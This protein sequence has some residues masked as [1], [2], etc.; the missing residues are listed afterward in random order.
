MEFRDV[1]F[2]LAKFI[3]LK[4]YEEKKRRINGPN[5]M[6]AYSSISQYYDLHMSSKLI[7]SRIQAVVEVNCEL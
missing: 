1:L 5:I 2:F 7:Q 3:M 6:V 4:K